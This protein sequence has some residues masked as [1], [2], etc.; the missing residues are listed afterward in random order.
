MT[1]STGASVISIGG[2]RGGI[3]GGGAAAAAVAALA[4]VGSADVGRDTIS[5][6]F[7]GGGDVDLEA[8]ERGLESGKSCLLGEAALA[9]VAAD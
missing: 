4:A 5:T 2:G 9:V 8:S 7:T 3:L 6:A 1:S